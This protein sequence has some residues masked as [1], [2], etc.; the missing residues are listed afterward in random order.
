[1][2]DR[3]RAVFLAGA[4]AFAATPA[5]AEPTEITVRVIS[6]DAKFV[7]SSMGG[8]A[9]TLR[10][11]E[12]GTVL[13]EGTIEGGTGNT[14]LI[15]ES[16]GRSPMLADDSAAAFTTSLDVDEPQLV[17]LEAHGPLGHP[18]SAIRVTQQRWI[19]PGEDVIAGGGWIVELPGMVIDPEV[20]MDGRL[21][22]ITAKV[23]PMCGCPITPGGI[24][25][26][27]EYEVTASLWQEGAQVA[28]ST[29]DFATAP[30]GYEGAIKLPKKGRYNLVLSARNTRTGNSGVRSLRV[31]AE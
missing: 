26:A 5:L 31:A 3:M 17:T 7:G 19:M 29:L 8:V 1:M 4:M 23:S 24:W 28:A 18:E 16:A 12:S 20:T 13:A 15:M 10:D 14:P 11:G 21:A 25:P 30:G 22:R 9:I 6:K 2:E 27:E